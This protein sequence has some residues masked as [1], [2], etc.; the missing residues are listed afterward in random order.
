MTL[1]LPKEP[2]QVSFRTV[3]QL[4]EIT[5]ITA[6]RPLLFA[7]VAGVLSAWGMNI[8]KADAFSNA[9]GIIVD[10]FQFTDPFQTL[11][12]N[13]SEID[14]FLQSIRD[15]AAQRVPV[16][17]LLRSRSHSSRRHSGEGRRRNTHR[18]RQRIV[19]TQHAAA[20]GIAGYNRLVAGDCEELRGVPLQH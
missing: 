2:V 14:R 11:A 15:V 18:I 3:R 20:G 7:D 9:A 12:L 13:P 5:L 16:E 1:D 17:K 6:D 4:N 19:D 10:T 8:V